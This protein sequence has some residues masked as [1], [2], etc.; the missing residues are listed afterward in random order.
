MKNIIAGGVF[1]LSL[2]L[3]LVPHRAQ[4]VE[5]GLTPSNVF[6]LWTN[7]NN[8]LI[9]TG[10][11]KD[12]ALL[13]RLRAINPQSF[14]GKKPGD[15]LKQVEAFRDKLDS[16]GTGYG[17]KPTPVFKDPAGGTVTPSVVFLNSGYVLDTMVLVLNKAD[18]EHLI[19]DYYLRRNFN[20]KTPSDVYAMV[21]LANRRIDALVP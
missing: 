10:Q 17:L 8:A 9:G 12:A 20:G 19:S 3:V 5:L 7:I 14:K 11:A 16:L 13:E 2:S 18:G 21:E 4:A 6:D 1:I 15:V